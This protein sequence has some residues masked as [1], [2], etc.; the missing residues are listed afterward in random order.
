MMEIS[1]LMKRMLVLWLSTSF[2]NMLMMSARTETS[3]METGSSTTCVAGN[4]GAEFMGTDQNRPKSALKIL[5]TFM[6][7]RMTIMG[8]R[9]GSVTWRTCCHL[10]APSTEAAS[11]CVRS[12]PVMAD[13]YSTVE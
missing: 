2:R 8:F 9:C 7:S 5:P 10:V 3:S 13:R 1:W 4:R 11:Y 12:M 6:M